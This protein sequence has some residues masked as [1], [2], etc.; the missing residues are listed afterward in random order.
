MMS[1]I[2]KILDCGFKLHV[3]HQYF[4]QKI[5]TRQFKSIMY[6][7]LYSLVL[8]LIIP[9]LLLMFSIH[10]WLVYSRGQHLLYKFCKLPPTISISGMPL[11]PLALACFTCWL[12]FMTGIEGILAS[13]FG[14]VCN[15]PPQ[16][17]TSTYTHGGK[18]RQVMM[19]ICRCFHKDKNSHLVFP[20]V[21]LLHVS[22]F[23]H[24]QT[25]RRACDIMC[26]S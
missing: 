7:V 17:K 12:Y 21:I 9:A 1:W 4:Y 19:Y 3:L 26:T 22:H 23:C 13:D 8:C 14:W 11:D 10:S 18:L 20:I 15:C 16:Y 2:R 6:Y 5:V 24:I 25:K